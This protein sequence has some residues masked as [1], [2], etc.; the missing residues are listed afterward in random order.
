[1]MKKENIVYLLF[2]LLYL[3]YFVSLK[4][5]IGFWYETDWFMANGDYLRRFFLKP[6][7][8][9]EYLGHFLLQFYKWRW[10]GAAI[11]TLI[12]LGVYILARKV[13][14]KLG[15]PDNWLLPAVLPS[16]L[17]VGIQCY[18]GV[19]LGE[20][21]KIL[22]FYGLLW[23]Y[24]AVSNQ[25]VRCV[26]FSLLFPFFYLLLSSGG[27][28]FLY[29][30]YGLY[31]LFYA[32]GRSRFGYMLLWAFLLCVYPFLWQRWMWIMPSEEL[33]ILSRVLSYSTVSDMLWILYGYGLLLIGLAY[34]G[35]RISKKGKRFFYLFELAVIVA[36]CVCVVNYF[37]QRN[38][39]L[40][41]RMDLAA[42]HGDWEEV[43]SVAEELEE[44]SREE[45][46][47][48]SLA[49]ASRGEL[50]EKLFD[51]PVWGIGCLYLPRSLEYH[52]SVV[53]SE[54]YYRL[55]IP[56]EALHW[57]LQASIATPMGMNFR[58][59]K[60]LI[61][62]NIQKGDNRL[63]DKYLAIMEQTMLHWAW[64]R[65]R[66]AMMQ[67]SQTERILPND[68]IDFFIGGRPFLS[69]MAR[70]LDAGRSPEM[71]LDYILCGLLLN[72]D[73]DKFC[74]LFSY[75]Y[76]VNG[77]R[78]IPKAYEEALLTALAM[79][80]TD[81]SHYPI[82]QDRRGAFADYNALIRHASKNKKEAAE[83]MK[84]FKDT[85]WY[86]FHFIDPKNMDMKG[87]LLEYQS[88]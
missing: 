32:K 6:G 30:T 33:Y 16:L 85:W 75:F 59:L 70:V 20:V 35:K 69:D 83:L 39:E 12:P 19:G 14:V 71:T 81:L 55:K 79:G 56:N 26:V 21:L 47:Y 24:V 28:V 23:G 29:V 67:A 63:A 2:P 44:W 74:Q 4:G 60:R 80:K 77:N 36:G 13:A 10:I 73:L 18:M 9:A 48:V 58:T 49:L 1:M 64:I 54:F 65:N 52:I 51:Y 22:F 88:H 76:K 84:R 62:I 57:T 17:L 82:S 43:L 66:R 34:L 45:F 68:K 78:K 72:K 15:V 3:F 42:E 87:N 27:C 50:P 38:T 11:L 46:Y 41:L 7:G 37:Y 31:E 61:D 86:Y 25:R 53:G 8:W 5:H 40:F